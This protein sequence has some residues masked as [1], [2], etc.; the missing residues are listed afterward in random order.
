M[1][2]SVITLSFA[3]LVIFLQ[4]CGQQSPDENEEDDEYSIYNRDSALF[5]VFQTQAIKTKGKVTIKM[6][7]LTDFDWDKV[8]MFSTATSSDSVNRRLGAELISERM[9]TSYPILVFMNGEEIAEALLL[10]F[11]YYGDTTGYD[12]FSR[13]DARVRLYPLTAQ[14]RAEDSS[15]ID[16]T[17]VSVQLEGTE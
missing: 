15:I 6:S 5:P 4:A 12:V 11:P 1:T 3:V 17:T 2:K 9:Y 14:V 13:S 16:V 8:H 7:E 10:E